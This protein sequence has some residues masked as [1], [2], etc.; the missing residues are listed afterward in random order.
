MCQYI[1]LKVQNQ[2]PFSNMSLVQWFLQTLSHIFIILKLFYELDII[3]INLKIKHG[4][5]A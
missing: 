1:Y 4:G 3:N 5:L 2:I